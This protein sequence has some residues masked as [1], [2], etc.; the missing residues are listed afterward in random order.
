MRRLNILLFER[1]MTQLELQ[2]LRQQQMDLLIE[3]A[4]SLKNTATM[5]PVIDSLKGLNDEQQVAFNAMAQELYEI[6]VELKT[7]NEANHHEA[8]DQAYI[9]LQK[10]CNTCHL[11]FRSW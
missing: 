3:E 10:T 2:R 6:T 5:I 8:V 7:E 4:E 11:L 9:K 1:E